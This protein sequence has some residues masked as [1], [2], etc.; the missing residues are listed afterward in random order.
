[1]HRYADRSRIHQSPQRNEQIRRQQP[2]LAAI[3]RCSVAGRS[4]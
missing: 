2:A 1:M 3:A 4:M